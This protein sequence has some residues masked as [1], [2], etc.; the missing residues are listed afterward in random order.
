MRSAAATFLFFVLLSSCCWF[1]NVSV[2]LQRSWCC[3]HAEGHS[4]V[5]WVTHYWCKFRNFYEHC[6]YALIFGGTSLEVG[7]STVVLAPGL[8]S[9]SLNRSD[10]QVSLVAHNNKGEL[11]GI[12]RVSVVKEIFLPLC[13]LLKT[14]QVCEVENKDAGIRATVKC[15]T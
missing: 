4:Q 14:L 1:F 11:C 7:V 10:C 2:E 13:Q 9:L 15:K 3:V 8:G 5:H 12:R 6:A